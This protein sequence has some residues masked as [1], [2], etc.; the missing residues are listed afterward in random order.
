MG[1]KY[2]IYFTRI[3]YELHYLLIVWGGFGKAG[4]FIDLF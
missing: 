4:P 3:I 1:A 2:K